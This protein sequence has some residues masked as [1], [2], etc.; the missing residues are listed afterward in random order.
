MGRFVGQGLVMNQTTS[1]SR[2]GQEKSRGSGMI[3]IY[4]DHDKEI[5]GW[6]CTKCGGKTLNEH[7]EGPHNGACTCLKCVSSSE[8]YK[9]HY[10]EIN[11][12]NDG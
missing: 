10:D 12:E 4:R 3:P 5:E 9:R 8:L 7:S 1:D 11:W 6:A 2:S